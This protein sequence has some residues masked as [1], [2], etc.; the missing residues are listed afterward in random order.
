MKKEGAERR[1]LS[2]KE[3]KDIEAAAEAREPGLLS[4]AKRY[5]EGQLREALRLKRLRD[6]TKVRKEAEAAESIQ[7]VE[8]GLKKVERKTH[9]TAADIEAELSRGKITQ[10]EA[11]RAMDDLVVH[12]VREGS[13]LFDDKDKTAKP[14]KSTP[15]PMEEK[16]ESKPAEEKKPLEP[17]KRAK[18]KKVV[19]PE[20]KASVDDYVVGAKGSSLTK[21]DLG[22]SLSYPLVR[23]ADGALISG[24]TLQNRTR[25]MTT[26]LREKLGNMSN[27]EVKT[28]DDRFIYDPSAESPGDRYI[29]LKNA[30]A[31]IKRNPTLGFKLKWNKVSL[32]QDVEPPKESPLTR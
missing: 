28:L 14:K 15:P 25:E 17:P 12:A 6:A 5:E 30:L 22:T 16:K 24:V 20:D 21:S 4:K 1:R 3:Q 27:R 10:S 19:P 23:F 2:A 26:M 29:S 8:T 31:R 11:N 18:K 9:A 7:K 32:I 13:S